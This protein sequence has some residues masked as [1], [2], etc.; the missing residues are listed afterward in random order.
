MSTGGD[1]I[2]GFDYSLKCG[3][4]SNH[5]NDIDDQGYT[6]V[7]DVGWTEIRRGIRE[8]RFPRKY[9][10]FFFNYRIDQPNDFGKQS[11]KAIMLMDRQRDPT[12]YINYNQDGGP[13]QMYRSNHEITTNAYG[14][15]EGINAAFRDGSVR[16]MNLAA[17]WGEPNYYDNIYDNAGYGEGAYPQFVDDEMAQ[18][19]KNP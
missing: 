17:V 8:F 5:A 15:A 18:I 12:V 1:P 13:Y 9:N 11:E 4:G 14:A 2:G 7:G 6:I 19:W 3:L 16:W 10:G